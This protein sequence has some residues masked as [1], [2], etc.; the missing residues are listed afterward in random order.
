MT[1][2]MRLVLAICFSVLFVVGYRMEVAG[3][4]WSNLATSVI[5]G[6]SL[7]AV[8][9]RKTALAFNHRLFGRLLK[10]SAPIGLG[11]LAMFVIHS[12]DRFFLQRTVSLAEV[13]IYALAYK[14]GC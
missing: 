3:V 8:C 7:S 1:S 4:L 5:I 14:L 12:G 9:L 11:G 10:F 2:L 13:G 6:V